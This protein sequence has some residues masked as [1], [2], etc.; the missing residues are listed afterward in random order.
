[1]PISTQKETGS[2][3][4]LDRQVFGPRVFFLIDLISQE[5][6]F[7]LDNIHFPFCACFKKV[8]ENNTWFLLIE[9]CADPCESKIMIHKCQGWC[10]MTESNSVCYYWEV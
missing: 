3:T 8:G 7:E 9:M 6:A 1:M 2:A 4:F 10:L 5:I